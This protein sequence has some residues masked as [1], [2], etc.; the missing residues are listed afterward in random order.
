MERRQPNASGEQVDYLLTQ[1]GLE[2]K[3]VIIALTSGRQMG[4]AR[5]RRLP[6]RSDGGASS[7]NCA[8]SAM[9]RRSLPTSSL[10][11]R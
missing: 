9:M 10:S 4:A 3:P 1:K 5:S 8:A 6:D 2:L 7:F 11:L